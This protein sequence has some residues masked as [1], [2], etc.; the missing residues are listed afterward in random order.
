M[1]MG[2][3]I[4]GWAGVREGAGGHGRV[5]P[6]PPRGHQYRGKRMQQALPRRSVA[7]YNVFS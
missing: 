7:G 1:F 6:F 3:E 5:H 2:A 4:S